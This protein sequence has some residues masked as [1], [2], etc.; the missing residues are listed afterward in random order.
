MFDVDI[1]FTFTSLGVHHTQ[2]RVR[3]VVTS[4]HRLFNKWTCFVTYA[5]CC[6]IHI[7]TSAKVAERNIAYV[8]RWI[9]RWEFWNNAMKVSEDNNG[10]GDDDS[11]GSGNH[12]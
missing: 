3:F 1:F 9:C 5:C 11:V 4:T 2:I 6:T 7:D 8:E 10:S 12:L